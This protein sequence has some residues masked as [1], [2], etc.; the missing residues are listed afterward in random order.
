MSKTEYDR[1]EAADGHIE[2]ALLTR[3]DTDT[4]REAIAVDLQFASALAQ[5]ESARHLGRIADAL[6][7]M[8]SSGLSI[9]R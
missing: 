4:G 8:L 7:E 2:S 6:E 5:Y 3:S 9:R 1:M